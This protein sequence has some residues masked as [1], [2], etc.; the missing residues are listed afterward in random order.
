M[1]AVLK[2]VLAY[3]LVSLAFFVLSTILIMNEAWKRHGLIQDRATSKKA[4]KR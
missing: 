2:G 1:D 4:L 3:F